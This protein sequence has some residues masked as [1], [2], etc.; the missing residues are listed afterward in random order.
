MPSF[1]SSYRQLG[2]GVYEMTCTL[3]IDAEIL[4]APKAYKYVVYSPKMVKHDD[5]FEYLHSFAGQSHNYGNPNRCLK[6]NHADNTYG[7]TYIV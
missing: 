2:E 3:I 6:I 1:F 5:C 7:G 4:K